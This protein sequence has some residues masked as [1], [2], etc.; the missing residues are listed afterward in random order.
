MWGGR[1]TT[2]NFSDMQTKV[3][4]PP[5]VALRTR[6]H[7]SRRRGRQIW[8]EQVSRQQ[9]FQHRYCGADVK[10]KAMDSRNKIKFIYKIPHGYYP[11]GAYFKYAP[12]VNSSA[13]SANNLL[14][15]ITSNATS[16]GSPTTAKAISQTT[17]PSNCGRALSQDA[18]E[19]D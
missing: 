12:T 5:Q 3:N 4:T 6:T 1:Q 11:G 15:W 7:E 2:K 13:W 9:L 10:T 14:V 18:P 16:S 19:T 17:T 8:N